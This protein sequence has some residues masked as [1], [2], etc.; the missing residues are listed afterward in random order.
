[1]ATSSGTKKKSSASKTKSK[2]TK[3]NTT[4]KAGSKSAKSVAKPK[5]AAKQTSDYEEYTETALESKA[6]IALIIS[7]ALLQRSLQS[8][9]LEN[10]SG[11][12]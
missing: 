11:N 8:S 4:S 9:S 6:Q 2:T 12:I 5:S 10:L 3:N 1:M 7:F